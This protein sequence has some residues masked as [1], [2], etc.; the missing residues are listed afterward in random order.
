MG[1]TVAAMI[2]L[3]VA[4]FGFLVMGNPIAVV[5]SR[6]G[7]RRKKKKEERRKKKKG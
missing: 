5:H 4:A 2:G 3:P 7:E 1:G 6:T